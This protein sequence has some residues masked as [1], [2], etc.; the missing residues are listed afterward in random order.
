M[1]YFKAKIALS[2]LATA[3][4]LITGVVAAQQGESTDTEAPGLEQ[5]EEPALPEAVAALVDAMSGVQRVEPLEDG[6]FA[7]HRRM[8]VTGSRIQRDITMQVAKDGSVVDWGRT[9][10][11]SRSYTRRQLIQTGEIDAAEA[12]EKLD[13]AIQSHGGR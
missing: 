10:M 9:P 13:P 1:S 5:S 11:F 12:L 3:F 6:L 2:A 7:V 4:L 8:S